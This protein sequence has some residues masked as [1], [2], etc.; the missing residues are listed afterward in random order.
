[1]NSYIS[2]NRVEIYKYKAKDFE[3]N[4]AR[5]CLNNVSK[6]FLVDDMKKTGLYGYVYEFSVDY[7]SINLM[8]SR[9]FINV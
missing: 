4:A 2:V 8:I 3:I 7:D 5:L 6:I 9:T 1:M